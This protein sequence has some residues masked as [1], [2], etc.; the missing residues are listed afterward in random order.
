MTTIEALTLATRI[1]KKKKLKINVHRPVGTG[2][3]FDEEGNALPPLATLADTRSDIGSPRIDVE[4]VHGWYEKVKEKLKEEDEVDKVHGR[5]LWKEKRMKEKMKW[6][7]GRSKEDEEEPSESD[8]EAVDMG[9]SKKKSK[10]Y[11]DTDS[12]GKEQVRSKVDI[13][14]DAISLEEQ[15]ALALKLLDSLHR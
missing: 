13:N 8:G 5:Q 10:V 6:K 14:T 15:E 4:K 9:G 1:L 12:D 2:V 3:V 7:R 11:F